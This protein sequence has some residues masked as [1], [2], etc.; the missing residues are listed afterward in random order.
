MDDANIPSLLSIPLL[1]PS[2]EMYDKTIYEE[3]KRFALSKQNQY[4]F[5]GNDYL[6]ILLYMMLRWC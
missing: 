4:Y 5:T 2:M 3:T 6:L 1:D